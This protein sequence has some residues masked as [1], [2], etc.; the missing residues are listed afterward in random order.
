MSERLDHKQEMVLD[1]LLAGKLPRNL[2]WSEVT[3]L[4][5][6]LGEV[7]PRAGN[8]NEVEFVI[9]SHSAFFKR[10]HGHSLEDEEVADLRRFLRG[11]GVGDGAT[12]ST[13]ATTTAVPAGRTVVV[14][15]HRAARIYQNA[16]SSAPEREETEK[17][18]DPHGFRR[19]LIHRK[20]AHYEG[21]RTPEEDSY[22][23]EVAQDLKTA[24]EIIL[25]G[26][27]TGKSSA[28]DFLVGYLK[29]R[30]PTIL[31]Q[32]I[33]TEDRDF[34]A[35]TDPEIEAIARQHF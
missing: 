17:P 35:L 28:V 7:R 27:G 4:I 2:A 13:S 31:A 24:K 1:S 6:R 12:T 30:H 26:H 32:V 20:E 21:Q 15:D 5:G 16:G 10:P 29:H 19:H 9:G 14:I 18:Y 25:I 23:E 22:Y 3:E 11:A 33:E 8:G 34:A